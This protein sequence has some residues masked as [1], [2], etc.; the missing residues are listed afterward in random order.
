MRKVQ[1]IKVTDLM[2]KRFFYNFPGSFDKKRAMKDWNYGEEAKITNKEW[3]LY[4][5]MIFYKLYEVID[6]ILSFDT[7]SPHSNINTYYPLFI[8][9][10]NFIGKRKL[11]Q[12]YFKDFKPFM[13]MTGDIGRM[14]KEWKEQKGQY[15]D[16]KGIIDNVYGL[17]IPAT[18]T[19][20]IPYRFKVILDQIDEILE[21]IRKRSKH[22]N[23]NR[24][25]ITPL[26]NEFKMSKNTLVL[27]DRQ[28]LFEGIRGKIIKLLFEAKG[29][30]LPIRTIAKYIN[31][32]PEQT[33]PIIDQINERLKNNKLHTL[34]GIKSD[35]QGN[36]KLTPYPTA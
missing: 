27:K 25:I 7:V 10:F 14:K 20:P 22:E 17:T 36:Y 8:D 6:T 30:P 15:I 23:I 34:I 33:R 35:K 32:S 5:K 26:P 13:S 21:D 24:F 9:V 16:Q 11:K 2:L 31:K 19:F 3:V 4:W 12:F 29:N 28:I 1:T 18:E